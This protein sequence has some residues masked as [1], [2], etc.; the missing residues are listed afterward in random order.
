MSDITKC[1][2][3]KCKVKNKCHRFTAPANEY[4]QAYFGGVPGKDETCDYFW[5][6][7]LYSL[8]GKNVSTTSKRSSRKLP[9]KG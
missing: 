5:Q 2:G 4:W 1:A 6:N 8:G 7:E 9:V 3:K